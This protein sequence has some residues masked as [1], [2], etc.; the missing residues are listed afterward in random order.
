MTKVDIFGTYHLDRPAKVEE[1]LRMFASEADVF[2]TEEPRVET[3]K[4]AWNRLRLYNPAAWIAG[5]L[6]NS[7]WQA[8][9]FL[10][11][12]QFGPVDAV[13]AQRVAHE[14][15]IRMVPVDANLAH[16]ASEV[17]RRLTGFSWLWALLTIFVVFVG[18][19]GWPQLPTMYGISPSPTFLISSGVLMGFLPI[20][21]IAYLTLD[22]RNETIVENIETFLEEQENATR[23]CLVVGHKHIDGVVEALDESAVEVGRRHKPE[24]FRKSL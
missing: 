22:E 2:F 21:P 16:R 23:G 13:V 8:V 24:F 19:V 1:E 4:S 20:V 15:D 3:S 14:R 11:T 6:L 5:R 17:N 9:G 7:L 18:V 10:F 12:R